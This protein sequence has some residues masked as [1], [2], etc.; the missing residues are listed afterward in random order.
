MDREHSSSVRVHFYIP[1]FSCL[2]ES[3]MVS[4]LTAIED[5]E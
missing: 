2:G 5:S 4:Q 1:R 3:L